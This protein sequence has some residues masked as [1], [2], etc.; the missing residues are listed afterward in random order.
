[1]LEDTSEDT[2]AMSD[3]VPDESSEDV[4]YVSKSGMVES[5]M[6]SVSISFQN[7][8]FLLNSYII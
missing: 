4:M 3:M 7:S 6:N 8:N 2:E 1:M 5:G